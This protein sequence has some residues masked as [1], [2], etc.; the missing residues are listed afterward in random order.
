M[1]Y[2]NLTAV[3]EHIEGI[4]SIGD[5]LFDIILTPGEA[6][7]L[8]DWLQ[9]N[10][11][12]LQTLE[13]TRAEGTRRFERASDDLEA[14]AAPPGTWRGEDDRGAADLETSRLPEGY[15]VRR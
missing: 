8:L 3:L 11:Q 1:K 4:V 5:H 13:R 14:V 9:E 7:A 6:L 15:T 10:K 2:C 12:Q